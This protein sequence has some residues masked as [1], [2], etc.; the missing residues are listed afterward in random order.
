[1]INKKKIPII[2]GVGQFTQRKNSS[3]PLDPLR[4]MIKTSQKA[5]DDTNV[6]NLADFVDAVY[7][8]TM[9]SW[10]YEDAPG[11]LSEK[12]NITP[13]EKVYLGDGGNSPQSLINRAAKAI[14]NGTHRS[15]L[16]T[17][18]E[19]AYTGSKMIKNT[20]PKGWPPYKTP[21]YREKNTY[22]EIND[23]ERL[24][25][26]RRA[27]IPY[28][29]FESAIRT[30]SKRSLEDHAKYL[31][32]LFARFSEVASKNPFSWTQ[33][34]Y[35][36]EEISTP[37]PINRYI[38]YPYTM[39]MCA[40]NFVDQSASV[41]VTSLEL[42]EQFNIDPKHCVYLMG[43]ADLNNIHE[44]TRRPLLYDSPAIKEG[45]KLALKQAS[46]TLDD[47]DKFDIYSCFPSI[48]EIIMRELG[49]K[50]E[51]PRNLTITGGLPYFGAPLSVYSLHA[52]VRTVE[53]IRDNPSL[54]IMVLA[55]GGYN[56]GES[57]GIYG[58]KP[59]L[60][61]WSIRDD[62]IIQQSI[63]DKKLP[64]P[65]ERANGSLTIDAYTIMYDRLGK[66]KRV[67]AIGTLE[68]GLRTIAVT[69]NYI[70][71]LPMLEKQDLVGRIFMVKYNSTVNRNILN[72]N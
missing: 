1:M 23:F 71:E 70:A 31:G 4:L 72:I 18:G 48:V 25:G 67:I 8:V 32:Y 55:N 5:I 17:G 56:S 16:I 53:M 40:N 62:S 45:S 44:I 34:Y 59:P 41:I 19:A 38:T 47:I 52:I 29:I 3:Q 24:Y 21:K 15:V 42:A 51:D 35:Q 49:I 37:S 2:I 66:I 65:I 14:F 39:R 69:E 27:A 68:N 20:L 63:I 9:I 26:F 10:S 64:L 22:G 36:A 30:I 60:I 43:S 6:N 54:N 28:A 11:E 12:L 33:K 61:P 50:K 7:M 57:V 58:S 13:K 46:L